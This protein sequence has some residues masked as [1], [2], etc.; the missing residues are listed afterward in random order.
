MS[1]PSY[2]TPILKHHLHPRARTTARPLL[3]I[4]PAY[5]PA[6]K[7]EF[8][9]PPVVPTILRTLQLFEKNPLPVLPKVLRPANRIR[10]HSSFDPLYLTVRRAR[11]LPVRLQAL[12][13]QFLTV[14]QPN[15]ALPVLGILQQR[16]LNPLPRAPKSLLLSTSRQLHPTQLLLPFL[17]LFYAVLMTHYLLLESPIQPYPRA[18]S[19]VL[20]TF[21]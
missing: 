3:S 21:K 14:K 7:L 8:D 19:L 5:E 15:L 9:L 1:G 20:F 2:N 16:V 12:V 18:M 6:T 11:T 4:S 17:G 10:T 13:R